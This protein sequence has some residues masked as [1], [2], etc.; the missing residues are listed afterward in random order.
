MVSFLNALVY[1]AGGVVVVGMV[2][3]VALQ[4]RLVYVPVLP[5]LARAYPITPARLRLDYEGVF[6]RA[7]DDVR[8]HA[9][10]VKQSPW[11]PGGYGTFLITIVHS[12]DF[13]FISRDRYRSPSEF[14]DP[15]NNGEHFSFYE[16]LGI[17][18]L[19]G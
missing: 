7:S 9:W 3:L 11:K 18:I 12:R 2:A 17:V 6:L 5:G 16:R 15:L 14:P 4:E 8:M 13:L 19:F 10:F 1:G